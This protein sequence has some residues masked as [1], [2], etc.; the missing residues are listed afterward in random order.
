MRMNEA[1]LSVRLPRAMLQ[2]VL[3]RIH[4]GTLVIEEG[5]QRCTYGNGDPVALVELR[6]ATAWQKLLRG[7]VGLADSYVEGLWDSPDLV[8]LIRLAARNA[9]LGT[10][11]RR[12]LAGVLRPV[13]LAR[14]LAR[15]ATRHRRRRDI[16]AHYDLGEELFKRMLD[17]TLTYSC[18]V[19]ERDDMTLEQAQLAKLD[20]VCD[21][22]ELSPGDRVLEIGT[23]WGSFA[24]HAART[25]G[26]NVTTTT[27]SPRQHAYA[28]ERVR[29]AGLER[30]V[31]VLQADYRDLKGSYDK[32]VSIEMIEAVGWRHTGNFFAA[33]SRLLEPHGAMLLQAITID[34][35]L[36]EFEK[37][38]RSF[39]KERIFPGGSLPSLEAI[40]R[41]LARHTDLQLAH[42]QDITAN[43]VRTLRSW[44]ERFLANAASLAG[45][46]YDER[47]RRLWIL[48]LAYCEAGFAERRI[49]DVQ[50]VLAKPRSRL[51]ALLDGR[52]PSRREFGEPLLAGG[53][54]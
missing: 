28:L 39:I 9:P 13:H 50:L 33:C 1:G 23:G 15:P 26:C 37:G 19:F 51:R 11:L 5:G 54:D 31:K 2:T 42:L 43:Y 16:A 18:A 52:L 53:S 21:K 34:D 38:S 24:L 6:R 8:A 4:T 41:D 48:Y 20:L 10:H 3:R 44:R 46:G 30:R 29:H 35:R 22:L 49:C 14:A 25:R 32:L 47:F 36:Y 7:S 12:R 40:A 27:I 17:P 45:L